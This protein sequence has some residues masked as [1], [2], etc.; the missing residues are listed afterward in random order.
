MMDV[1][2][3]RGLSGCMRLKQTIHYAF[4]TRGGAA[5]THIAFCIFVV[6]PFELWAQDAITI[7]NNN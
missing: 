7:K 5:H 2:E 6:A 4:D 1:R 3:P